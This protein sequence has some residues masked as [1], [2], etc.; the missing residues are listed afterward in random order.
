MRT[1]A[2]GALVLALLGAGTGPSSATANWDYTCKAVDASI[3]LNVLFNQGT[4]GRIAVGQIDAAVRHAGKDG[5]QEEPINFASDDIEQFW[6]G[7]DVFRISLSRYNGGQPEPVQ[8][9]IDTACRDKVCSGTYRYTQMGE[10]VS[11]KI[12]CEQG[13]AG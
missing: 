2:I 10:A 13:E 5:R 7:D 1:A 6:V 8:L 11:G 9:L 4:A 3:D 12:T